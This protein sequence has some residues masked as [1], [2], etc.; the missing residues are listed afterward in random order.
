MTDMSPDKQKDIICFCSGTTKAKIEELI[1]KGADD[2]E[3]LES[4]T[5]VNTGCGGCEHSLL[6]LLAKERT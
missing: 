6:E 4:A 5:G 2:M 1:D 3:K